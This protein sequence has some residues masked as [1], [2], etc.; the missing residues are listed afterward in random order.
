MPRG[1]VVRLCNAGVPPPRAR[2]LAGD[3]WCLLLR[4]CGERPGTT[5]VVTASSRTCAV[6]T[7][8][9]GRCE[10]ERGSSRAGA[11]QGGRGKA[12]R[13]GCRAAGC[14]GRGL[15]ACWWARWCWR[16][17]SSSRDKVV[18]SVCPP[19]LVSGGSASGERTAARSRTRGFS[20][21]ASGEGRGCPAFGA[22]QVGGVAAE[23]TR[24]PRRARRRGHRAVR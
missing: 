22:A 4:R 24:H 21:R 19:P 2:G 15:P 7:D 6:V 11:R 10:L 14:A 1:C 3:T 9:C 8:A 18:G 23:C 5:L 12:R 13:P 16:W 20:G 17:F